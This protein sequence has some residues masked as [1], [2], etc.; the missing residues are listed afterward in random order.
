MEAIKLWCTLFRG[1]TPRPNGS[2]IGA[3]CDSGMFH[4]RQSPRPSRPGIDLMRM[5]VGRPLFVLVSVQYMVLSETEGIVYAKLLMRTGQEKRDPRGVGWGVAHRGLA[6]EKG[7]GKH[8][9]SVWTAS[10]LLSK[11]EGV[12]SS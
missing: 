11:A 12:E 1:V 6:I 2:S 7:G 3:L 10:F 9:H 4:P 5:S 8:S